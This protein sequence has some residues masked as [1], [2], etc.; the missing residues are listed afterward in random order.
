MQKTNSVPA[1]NLA[2]M[3]YPKEKDILPDALFYVLLVFT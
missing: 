2:G 1:K 3:V